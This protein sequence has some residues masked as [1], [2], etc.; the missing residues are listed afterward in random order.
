MRLK[1]DH[2]EKIR[3]EIPRDLFIITAFPFSLVINYNYPQ[4]NEAFSNIK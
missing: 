4:N 2:I 1:F 3:I